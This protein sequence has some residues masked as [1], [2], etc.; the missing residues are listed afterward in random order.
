MKEAAK[1][2]AEAVQ[3]AEK[4]AADF[5]I[6]TVSEQP[7]AAPAPAPAAETD[8]PF[9]AK[10]GD[11]PEEA[12]K[13]VDDAPAKMKTV[14][15]IEFIPDVDDEPTKP[16]DDIT[17]VLHQAENGAVI[18]GAVA[19]AAAGMAGAAPEEKPAAEPLATSH[20]ILF[21]SPFNL[22]PAQ[23]K[24]AP[25][26]AAA[27]VTPETVEPA[28]AVVNTPSEI[29]FT[30]GTGLGETGTEN[31]ILQP[32]GE[33]F[34]PYGKA[35]SDDILE[36]KIHTKNYETVVEKIKE[37]LMTKEYASW[38]IKQMGWKEAPKIPDAE[39]FKELLDKSNK[40]ELK[41]LQNKTEKLEEKTD[42]L[43]ERITILEDSVED[44]QKWRHG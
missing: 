7:A 31:T 26:P 22:N 5:E 33:P 29:V 34:D 36:V 15:S 10:V 19:G 30:A 42:K 1:S 2:D 6:P 38:R 14:S 40:A 21:T 35:S 43:E 3:A 20:P 11:H 27:P 12:V 17:A 37:F 9:V 23:E 25:A 18:A 28:P 44:I 39:K 4:A 13:A 24:P 32:A 41:Y 16:V 8:S